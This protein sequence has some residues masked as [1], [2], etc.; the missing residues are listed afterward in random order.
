MDRMS[1]YIFCL[2]RS[3]G[4]GWLLPRLDSPKKIGFGFKFDFAFHVFAN[5]RY[6]ASFGIFFPF[7]ARFL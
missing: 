4:Q 1:Q 5:F 6:R 2:V 7:G 3:N